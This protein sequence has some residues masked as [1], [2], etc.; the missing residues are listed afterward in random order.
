MSCERRNAN[1]SRSQFS[2]KNIKEIKKDYRERFAILN[3]GQ[4]F[5]FNQQ[6]N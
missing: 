6:R 1:C 3:P 2:R 5:E 4:L